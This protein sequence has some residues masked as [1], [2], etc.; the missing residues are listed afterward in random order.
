MPTPLCPRARGTKTWPSKKEHKDSNESGRQEKQ[1]NWKYKEQKQRKQKT[2]LKNKT[3]Q[4]FKMFILFSTFLIFFVTF[5]LFFQSHHTIK[6][7][8]HCP[9]RKLRAFISDF[10]SLY[11]RVPLNIQ[12][13]C[14][15]PTIR[16]LSGISTLGLAGA[17]A[18]CSSCMHR[19]QRTEIRTA[20]PNVTKS[21]WNL[22][23]S[24]DAI[25]LQFRR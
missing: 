6:V 19:G 22:R 14:T 20:S 1:Q 25:S 2:K 23:S 13:N 17:Q 10:F 24:P 3:C 8:F 18:P 15:K 5:F 11:L 21:K 4:T 9:L 16:Q 12:K 7:P